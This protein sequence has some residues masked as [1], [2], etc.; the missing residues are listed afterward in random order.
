MRLKRFLND[1]GAQPKREK[2][3]REGKKRLS[4]GSRKPT[5]IIL[6]RIRVRL[7]R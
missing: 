3:K 2:K 4:N 6:R 7:P 1:D 5:T